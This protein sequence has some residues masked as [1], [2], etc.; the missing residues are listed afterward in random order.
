M[1]KST[2]VRNSE[3][4]ECLRFI[5]GHLYAATI[6]IQPSDDRMIANHINEAYTRCAELLRECDDSYDVTDAVAWIE[7]HKAGDNLLWDMPNKPCT[8]L[9]PGKRLEKSTNGRTPPTT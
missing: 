2:M 9:Y 5:R 1:G 8:P 3:L 4:L 7:H 6:Q